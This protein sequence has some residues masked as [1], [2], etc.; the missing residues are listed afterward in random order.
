[1]LVPWG[2]AARSAQLL[3]IC[4]SVPDSWVLDSTF[5]TQISQSLF[6]KCLSVVIWII[7][8]C[9]RFSSFDS[10]KR[11]SY[12]YYYYFRS[13]HSLQPSSGAEISTN[14]SVQLYNGETQQ[15]VIKLENIGMEPLEKL[16][17]TSKILTT[18]GRYFN[19]IWPQ[20]CSSS[21]SE[22]EILY[23]TSVQDSES[24]F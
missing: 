16:E 15:L 20:K 5:K 13:A 10:F 24:F 2:G 18:K 19:H 7:L 6:W 23:I 12:N 22:E 17:V 9:P 14:V 4:P 11:S 3:E 1:M 8:K 21:L